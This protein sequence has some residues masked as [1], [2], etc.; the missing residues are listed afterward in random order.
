MRFKLSPAV[1]IS[2]STAEESAY[3][4]TGSEPPPHAPDVTTI[5]PPG[6]YR[7]VDDQLFQIIQTPRSQPVELPRR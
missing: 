1:Q 2:L 5:M 6:V 3:Y 7:V 4:F